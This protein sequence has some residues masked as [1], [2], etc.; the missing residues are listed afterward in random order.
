M[1]ALERQDDLSSIVL[2]PLLVEP[3][4]FPQ[5]VEELSSIQEVY[6]KV[7]SFRRLECVVELHYERVVKSF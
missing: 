2:S 4:I 3:L 6:Y 7:E 5:V 1:Q